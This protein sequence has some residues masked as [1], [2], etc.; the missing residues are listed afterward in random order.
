ML[1]LSELAP[2]AESKIRINGRDARLRALSAREVA[3]IDAKLPA[4]PSAAT[5]AHE[6][7]P[8]FQRQLERWIIR[9]KFACAALGLD[10]GNSQDEAFTPARDAEW[11][12]RWIDDIEHVMTEDQLLLAYAEQTRLESLGTGLP[13]VIGD[14]QRQGYLIGPLP[15]LPESWH[16]CETDWSLPTEAY[17]ETQ[18]CAFLRICERFG[19]D[20][21]IAENLWPP[22][23]R[24][25]LHGY[26]RLREAEDLRLRSALA[27]AGA[28]SETAAA[29][30]G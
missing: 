1:R 16:D 23:L 24:K 6:R 28:V 18:L 22:S 25:L 5:E 21:A 26:E 30:G 7:M 9:K 10:L 8:E 27:G 29:E 17:G 19:Q 2:I 14:A 12:A 11:V 3:L 15:E 4:R 20:P 13:G